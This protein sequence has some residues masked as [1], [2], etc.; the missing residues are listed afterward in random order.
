MKA[1]ALALLMLT[2]C[3]FDPDAPSPD[4]APA[5]PKVDGWLD[6]AGPSLPNAWALRA[7]YVDG[8]CAPVDTLVEVTAVG[9]PDQVAVPDADQSWTWG[10]VQDEGT[11]WMLLGTQP[12][13]TVTFLVPKTYET[14]GMTWVSPNCTWYYDLQATPL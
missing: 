12:G 14:G 11:D 1:I 2:A 10:A 5:G 7:T 4:H 9:L 13:S 6:P 3:A 8:D